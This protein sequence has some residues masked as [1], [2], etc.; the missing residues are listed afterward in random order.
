[1]APTPVVHRDVSGIRTALAAERGAGR[2][3]GFV[4]T[5]GA[6]HAGHA[7]LVERAAA[8][9][10]VVAVSVFVNPLQFGPGEDL[11]RYPRRLGED[12]ELLGGL[13]VAYVFA[14][15]AA[16]FTPPDRVTT[17]HVDGPLTRGLEGASRPGHFDGVATIV[18]KLL[19]VVAPDVACFGEKDFQQL[20]V[21]RAL[22]RDLDLPV[23]IV[24]C[25]IVRDS[26]GLAL[27]SRNAHLEAGQR[28]AALALFRALRAVADG[29]DGDADG[30]RTRLRNDLDS[31]PGVRL[32]YADV[33]DP[34]TLEPLIAGPHA[35]A[36]ALV[37]AWVGTTRLIDNVALEGMPDAA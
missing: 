17:V 35:S 18:T 12:V 2:S 32:D 33:V 3:V 9:C 5:M 37:A 34:A 28:D 10:D 24:G 36:R 7:S 16:A 27:S 29:W 13:G 1:M 20:A 15:D 23:A 4:P 14:P 25:P 19:A 21:V 31:A 22:V 26:D 30:A 11:D 6:L 8:A